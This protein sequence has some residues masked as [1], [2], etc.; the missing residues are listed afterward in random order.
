V[1]A[2]D[3]MPH[4]GRLTIGLYNED[5]PGADAEGRRNGDSGKRWVCLEVSDTGTGIDERTRERLFEPFFTTKGDGR[6]TGLG[7]SI[8]H[9]IVQQAGGRVDVDTE[10]GSGTCFRVTFPRVDA[11]AA[12]SDDA[13]AAPRSPRRGSETILLV[14]D[15]A[16]VRALAQRVLVGHGYHVLAA[17]GPREARLIGAR[18]RGPIHL[19]L[20]DVVMPK[21]SGRDLALALA[22]ERGDLQVLFMTGYPDSLAAGDPNEPASLLRKPFGPE[23]LLSAVREALDAPGEAT[24]RVRLARDDAPGE[25]AHAG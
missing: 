6:G 24:R 11:A 2:R 18:E 9:E 10:V 19:L 16:S 8:V 4:G 7:L 12:M 17:A 5:G 14:E 15:D 1:N 21:E 3:A 13:Y 25:R 20:T 23:A 22:A